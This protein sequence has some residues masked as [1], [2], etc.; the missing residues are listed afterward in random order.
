M[1][2]HRDRLT[3]ALPARSGLGV[4]ALAVLP[5]AFLAVF[6]AL[7]VGGMLARGFHP[8]GVWD[9]SGV[10]EVLGRART[11]RVLAFTL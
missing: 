1:G 7:P 10:G 8:E 9:L 11:G 3:H 2:R 4:I 5:L 6:F